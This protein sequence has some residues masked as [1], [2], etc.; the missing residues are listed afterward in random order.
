VARAGILF[1]LCVNSFEIID[2][3]APESN[4]IFIDFADSSIEP[5]FISPNSIGIRTSSSLFFSA[6]FFGIRI[7]SGL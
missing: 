6:H 4:K 1:A 7:F 2:P 3:L 5:V